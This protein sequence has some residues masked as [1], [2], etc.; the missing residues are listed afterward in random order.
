MPR[1][2]LHTPLYS[3]SPLKPP[4]CLLL[5]PPRAACSTE[6]S[7]CNT[8][9]NLLTPGHPPPGGAGQFQRVDSPSSATRVTAGPA[10]R[11]G[12]AASSSAVGAP[13]GSS[14]PA[15]RAEDGTAKLPPRSHLKRYGSRRRSEPSA[16]TQ[17]PFRLAPRA[18]RRSA[19]RVRRSRAGRAWAHGERWS[20]GG[21]GRDVSCA[22]PGKRRGAAEGE[23]DPDRSV[24]AATG[25][26]LSAR[27]AVGGAGGA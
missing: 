1:Q 9:S 18:G 11:A 5:V 22:G 3:P 14:T 21:S 6:P 4:A 7:S 26:R 8:T 19:A 24:L 17:R 27:A 20:R 12:A 13:T 10:Q 2:R 23:A 16:G 15:L 25:G